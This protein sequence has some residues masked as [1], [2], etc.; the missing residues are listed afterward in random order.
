L[1]W[2]QHGHQLHQDEVNALI[3]W[4]NKNSSP[5]VRLH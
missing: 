2:F 1:E 3:T 4:Y 5:I